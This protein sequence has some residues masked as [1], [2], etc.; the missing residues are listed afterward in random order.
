[1]KKQTARKPAKA[2][3][4]APPKVRKRVGG[5]VRADT[6]AIADESELLSDLRSL[7]ESARQRI[8]SAANATITILF[9]SVG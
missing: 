1:M 8:A 2:F 5:S 9:W 3:T 6:P 7:I 4:A